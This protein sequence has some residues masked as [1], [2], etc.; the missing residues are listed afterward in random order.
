[1]ENGKSEEKPEVA[2]EEKP[3][4]A[5]EEKP[6]AEAKP[7]GEE[8]KENEGEKAAE[9]AEKSDE[10]PEEVTPELL[11]KIKS[12]IEFYFGDCNMQRDK[13]LIDQ[14]KLDEGW[15]PMSIMLKFK[16]LASISQNVET[17]LKAL[18]D[19]ELMEISEDRKKIR[20]SPEKPLPVYDEAYKKAQEERSV[21]CKGFPLQG[22]TVQV[23]KEFFKD[24]QP[25]E[26][27]FMRRYPDKEKNQFFFKGSIFIQFTTLEGAKDFMARESVK[28]GDKELIRKWKN[29]YL[30]EK[31]KEIEE[32][33]SKRDGK[34]KKTEKEEEV[35]EAEDPEDDTV[36]PKGA[37]LSFT[38]A[39]D[40]TL[41]E[42]I[43][44]A[45]VKLAELI[46]EEIAFM[47]YEKG[48]SEGKIRFHGEGTATKILKKFTDKE[49]TVNESTLS[50]R[51][52]E[53]EEEEEYL[54]KVKGQMNQK[55]QKIKNNKRGRSKRGR[56]GGA[57]GKKRGGSPI[58]D[59][60]SKKAAK[61]S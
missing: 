21:Y 43:K 2:S 50:F 1:M 6:V 15:I 58:R 28:Y 42:D 33:K 45:V 31:K 48:N 40:D 16:A 11:E 57:R 59:S 25:H 3:E 35:M 49:L 32:R 61:T 60:P 29:D 26:T 9:E 38:G 27:I 18:E 37:V 10:T 19:S 7:E 24:F 34:G 4:A 22:T 36:L 39:G 55:K 52:V 44:E 20:R 17:I 8:T 47:D 23:L 41:R 54:K 13:F 5:P 51:L 14:V 30:V 53:G 56:G 46:P 12:Q